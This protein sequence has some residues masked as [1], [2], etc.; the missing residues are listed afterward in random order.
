MGILTRVSGF[1][2]FCG[3]FHAW[4]L[5]FFFAAVGFCRVFAW[6][7]LAGSRMWM[8]VS[9]TNDSA[10]WGQ[11]WTVQMYCFWPR[12]GEVFCVFVGTG[13]GQAQRLPP[14][15]YPLLK[16]HQKQYE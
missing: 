6:Q 3:V 14:R 2:G 7:L 1:V 5:A 12:L 11:T 13:P 9:Y 4:D 8:V 15:S 10:G 16:F